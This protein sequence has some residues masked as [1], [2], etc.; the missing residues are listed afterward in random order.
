MS[1]DLERTTNRQAALTVDTPLLQTWHLD[2]EGL[3]DAL[4]LDGSDFLCL[5]HPS[6]GA[7]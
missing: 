3:D 7:T 1:G 2:K 5:L 6:L 4:L